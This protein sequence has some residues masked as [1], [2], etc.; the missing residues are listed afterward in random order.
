MN[1]RNARRFARVSIAGVLAAL[2]AVVVASVVAALSP[3]A[4]A[5]ASAQSKQY[6]KKVMI[7]HRTGSQTNP[8]VTIV[9]S[10]N[11]LP[12]HLAHGDTTGSCG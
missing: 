9:V 5:A 2:I 8:A 7:C 1:P 12:A 4:V 11:A 3:P 10:V 6:E